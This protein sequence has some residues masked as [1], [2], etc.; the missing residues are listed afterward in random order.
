MNSS[1]PQHESIAIVGMAGRFPKARNIA[2][3]WDN[4]KNRRECISFFNDEEFEAAG[5]EF[6]KRNGKVVKARGMLEDADKFDAAFFGINA[7]EAEV[8]DP[9]QRIF[10]ECAHDA[11]EDAGCDPEREARPIG[12]FAG[13]SLNTYFI[14]QL[15]AH[16]ELQDTVNA[17]QLLLA[18]DKDFLATRL[19]YKLNLRGPSLT[20]QTACSTSL[21]AVCV[22]C[23]NLLTFQCDIA[24]A[25]CVSVTF[26]QKHN[27][28][29]QEGGITSPDG[30]CRAFDEKAEGTVPGEGAGVVVVKRLSDAIADGDSIYA[31]IKG[32]AM[33]NDGAMKAGYTAPSET[34][35]AEVIAWAQAMAGVNPE[36]IGYVEA[37]GTATPL[38]D[39][40]EIAGLTRAFRTGTERKNFCAIG[41]IKTVIG[42]LDVAAGMAGLI[43]ATLALHHRTIPPSLNFDAPNPKID[44]SNSPFYVNTQAVEWKESSAPR[45]AGVSSFG[46]GSTNTHVILE[47]AP[48][49]TAGAAPRSHSPQLL[50]LSARTEATLAG[51]C[52]N[53]AVHLRDHPEQDLADVAFTL[54]TGRRIFE[55]RR[56]IICCS[57]EEA[58][59]LLESAV[60]A[61]SDSARSHIQDAS[62]SNGN[63][64]VLHCYERWLAGD[65]VDWS[66]LHHEERRRVHLPTYPF[67]RKRFWFEPAQSD[68]EP[69][70]REVSPAVE[71]PTESLRSGSSTESELRKLFG[72]LLGENLA[73]A[74]A[75]A[76]FLELGFDSLV[77]TQ[78]SQGIEKKFGV[79]VPFGQLMAKLSTFNTLTAHLDEAVGRSS[80]NGAIIA[81]R[82]NGQLEL[83]G[84]K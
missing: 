44:F 12:V 74:D 76:T 26:P 9:Q 11:L 67:E 57:R 52:R 2:E 13:A 69:G 73:E 32:F 70:P 27:H 75:G 4:V 7:K 40:I 30:H 58:I 5:I 80:N 36:S 84:A 72:E 35:Q 18:N 78:A 38:G 31:V 34:G 19:S 82:N 68:F 54:Q 61:I 23:Q 15:L 65:R 42:H 50:V 3:L 28:L 66:S 56:A 55:H 8:M 83:E 48:Q 81:A 29:Y 17:Y 20:V 6:P 49:T 1:E 24:V 53:F 64:A 41:S 22:A 63:A 43:N 71:L 45:R 59:Q 37:H 16:P 10:L 46:I 33:N 21:V 14:S 62:R 51:M 39:P 77:L 47:E 79:R 60:S 25:G